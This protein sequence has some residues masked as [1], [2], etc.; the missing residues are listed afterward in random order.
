MCS[1]L[2]R[3]LSLLASN[4][5]CLLCRLALLNLSGQLS[6]DGVELLLRKHS[7]ALHLLLQALDGTL[8]LLESL[9]GLKLLLL[10]LSHLALHIVQLDL[11]PQ[12]HPFGSPGA[13]WY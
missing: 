2:R 7:L 10:G 12:L 3:L 8:S 4:V 6:L 5:G 1:L 13:G 9:L 11:Q